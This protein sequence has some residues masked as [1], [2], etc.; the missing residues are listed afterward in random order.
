MDLV[1]AQGQIVVLRQMHL[2]QLRLNTMTKLIFLK[3]QVT[4]LP[5]RR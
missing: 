4:L 3:S 2:I 1:Y 5:R